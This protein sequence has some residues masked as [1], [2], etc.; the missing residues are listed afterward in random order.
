MTSTTLGTARARHAD[1]GC[2]WSPPAP[3]PR[4]PTPTRRIRSQLAS[5]AT[6]DADTL[7]R[8][9]AT[10]RETLQLA[11]DALASFA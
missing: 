1:E 4:S 8:R 10:A 7:A 3:C 6:V 5:G 9:I 2:G 11:E